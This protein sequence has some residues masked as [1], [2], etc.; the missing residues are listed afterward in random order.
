[1]NGHELAD[2]RSLALHREIA[3]VLR[4]DPAR[5]AKVRE[6]VRHWESDG[7]VHSHYAEEWDRLL[8][9][10]IEAL[11]DML[12]DSGEHARA[13]R[14]VTPFA[15][16]IDPRSRWRIWREVRESAGGPR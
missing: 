1:M 9:G 12:V 6:R 13:L 10:P 15:G 3:A 16:F 7:T 5:L 8:A 2:E 11:L 4:R 14:Q